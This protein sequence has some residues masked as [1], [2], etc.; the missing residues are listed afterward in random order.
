MSRNVRKCEQFHNHQIFL[1]TRTILKESTNTPRQQ[2]K[3]SCM[4]VSTR[5][6]PCTYHG[7]LRT[8]WQ[9][10]P[11]WKEGIFL[12]FVS[13]RDRLICMLALMNITKIF[14]V[15]SSTQT[16][17]WTPKLNAQNEHY[18]SVYLHS[19]KNSVT[20]PFN[21]K[22][23]WH[24]TYNGSQTRSRNH[25]YR[26]KAIT[27]KYYDRVSASLPSLF[28]SKSHLFCAGLCYLWPVWLYHIS[29]QYLINSTIFGKKT[30][31]H[32]AESFLRS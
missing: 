24:C 11:T 8:R 7:K 22:Q 2:N 16:S 20:K 21:I 5:Q 27:I 31:L 26:G 13:I 19:R 12:G 9:V 28:G 10:I 30:L 25:C 32:G 18:T 6:R 1:C 23:D 29:V 14:L 15:S 4:R 3:T 17:I